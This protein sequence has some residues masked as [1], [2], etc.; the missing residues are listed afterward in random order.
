MPRLLEETDEYLTETLTEEEEKAALSV[1]PLSPLA[2]T[3]DL[4]DGGNING[5]KLRPGRDKSAT[6]GRPA[7]R[8][9]W[10]WNGTY[11]VLPLAWDPDGRVHDGARRYLSKRHCLCC[12]ASGFRGHCR[13]CRNNACINCNAGTDR[14]KIIP[15]FYLRK[16][17][18]PFP[19]KFY[20]SI[21]CFLPLCPRQGGR[22]F[23][24][25][26]DMRMH[27]RTRHRMEYQVHLDTIAASKTD[28]VALL[29]QQVAELT[30]KILSQSDALP[31]KPERTEEQK[32]VLRDRM[33]K[34]RAMR[35]SGTKNTPLT[36]Q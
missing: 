19:A 34:A 1:A 20:G 36:I 7:A 22:G 32:Q 18:V 6:R 31:Q 16:E 30:T 13:S 9:A 26:E 35:K 15:C 28:E 24:T 25:Q 2:Q 17:D 12:G 5:V 33:A 23:Q 14:K 29:R 4:T 10:M 3:P 27:A 11:T 21:P 8:G